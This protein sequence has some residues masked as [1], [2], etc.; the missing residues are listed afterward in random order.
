MTLFFFSPL[1]HSTVTLD[2]EVLS[3]ETRLVSEMLLAPFSDPIPTR[4][5]GVLLWLHP[6]LH[7]QRYSCT[8]PLKARCSAGNPVVFIFQQSP[9]VTVEHRS[10]A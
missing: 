8:L 9:V 7:L 5:V 3:A 1:P 2:Q 6:E 10:L 4:S